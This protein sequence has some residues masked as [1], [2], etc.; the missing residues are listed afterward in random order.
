MFANV[1]NG[2]RV[3]ITGHTGFKGSWLAAWLL[4]LGAQVAGYACDIPTNP[5]HFEAM[6]LCAHIKDIRADIRDRDR[7]KQ[8]MQEWKPDIL[9]HLAAQA[10]VRTSYE[11]PITTFESN[12]LGTLNVLESMR[13]C[14]SIQAAVII[15]SDKCYRNDEQV[16]GY[17]ENDALGGHDP[18]SASKGCAEIIAHS[19]FSSFFHNGPRCV[20]VRAGNVIGGGDWAKDR[21]VPDCAR[22]WAKGEPVTIRN[23]HATRPWQLVLEP[24][25][26]YLLVAQKLLV[27]DPNTP[28]LHGEA[29]N[30]GPDASVHATVGDVVQGLAYHWPGFQSTMLP[31]E[32]TQ[33]KECTLLKLCCDKAL[34]HL[35]WKATLTFE[36]TVRET[37]FWYHT[38]YRG[39]QKSMLDCTLGQIKSYVNTAELR[40]QPWTK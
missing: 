15:T 2:K 16:W 38:Y 29:Y 17:R 21:I 5:S 33:A 34:A 32:Q 36:E 6:G 28:Q 3:F 23:P 37:A 24:L 20:T 19:Y 1:F 31:T 8:A 12:M 11:D 27:P 30:F 18:Y 9:F 40:N 25:S 14:P 26:G 13:H 7:L 35:N 10:L 22:A 39:N 4:H